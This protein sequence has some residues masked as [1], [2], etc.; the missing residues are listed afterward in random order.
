MVSVDMRRWVQ[1]GSVFIWNPLLGNFISGNVYRG[2]LKQIC[3]P[4]LNCY[5]CPG[6]IGS[7]PLGSLQTV[8]ADP[9]YIWSSYAA[10]W[11]VLFG[12]LLGRWICG[13]VCP[14][15][16]VQ[17]WLYRV[18]VVKLRLPYWLSWVKYLVLLLF[19]I[20]LPV[21]G[22]HTF[23]LGVPAFCK[24]ICPAGTLEAGVPLVVVVPGLRLAIGTL[25]LLKIA[26]LFAVIIF[27][28][29]I[30]RPFC[31][32]LCPLG[33]IYGLFNP[34]SWYN[35]K[36]NQELCSDCGT[37]AHHCRMEVDPARAANSPECIRCGECIGNC[38]NGALSA[39][40][41]FD[42]NNEAWGHE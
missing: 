3:V 37:C 14:F 4:A 16:M 33:A 32:V 39:G 42:T 40:W 31:R 9:F 11:L 18:P 20:A 22:A 25:F 34:L 21:I 8:L 10:G 2:R 28:L 17:E 29:M 24:Y 19:V 27:S 36:H 38:P 5:S 15:G 13:W 12:A 35:Y 41:G 23:G 6:A 30:F 1:L 7:C 26:I